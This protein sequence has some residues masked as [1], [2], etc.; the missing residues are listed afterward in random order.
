MTK[1]GRRQWNSIRE[2]L[3]HG[4]Y[5]RWSAAT[6][7]FRLPFM[8]A[9]LAF[10]YAGSQQRHSVA[11]G[12]LLVTVWTI[13]SAVAEPA[14]GR[15]YDRVGVVRWPPRVLAGVGVGI[16]AIG[17]SLQ[18][19]VPDGGLIAITALVALATSGLSGCVRLMLAECIPDRLMQGALS[20][21]SSVIEATVIGAPLIVAAAA[22]VGGPV[23]PVYAM[24]VVTL[25][26][27]VLLRWRRP[28]P[29]AVAAEEE[30]GAGAEQ[31]A[32]GQ[33]PA[34]A[35]QEKEAAAG[36]PGLWRD[37]M[38][39]FWLLAAAAFGQ[40]LGSL[41]IGAVPISAHLHHGSAQA[42]IFVA[43]LGVASALAGI[44]FGAL[45][46]RIRADRVTRACALF[47][48]MIVA[49]VAVSF[50]GDVWS[51]VACYLA[52]GL[53]TAPLNATISYSVG[54]D[55]PPSRQAEAFGGIGMANTFAYAI[56][57]IL[58]AVAPLS[59]MLRCG[60]ALALAG[61]LLA[62]VLRARAGVGFQAQD[63]QSSI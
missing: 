30:R 54:K 9:P 58:L 39:I 14:I 51:V 4:G 53:C 41:E 2:L 49:G 3:S 48:V 59:V 6:Q 43:A 21:D 47:A 12:G 61:L 38:F 31:A 27:A 10:V 17:A 60:V 55:I 16:F 62:P 44:V 57:G 50:A 45:S 52:I 63:Q 18:L 5:W 8:M 34:G 22:A 13:G 1:S 40:S 19:G 29:P 25:G 42:A 36:R 33:A 7:A 28:V 11:L 56:P 24:G 46:D 37:P 23:Y 35:E 26:A 20:L 15:V 32:D